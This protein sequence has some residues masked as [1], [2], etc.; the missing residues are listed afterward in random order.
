MHS[1]HMHTLFHSVKKGVGIDKAM[2]AYTIAI[3]AYTCRAHMC[4]TK[5]AESLTTYHDEGVVCC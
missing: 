3:W 1:T 4:D 2:Q 5:A